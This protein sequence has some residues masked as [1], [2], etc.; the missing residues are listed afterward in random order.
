MIFYYIRIFEVKIQRFE[1]LNLIST[2]LWVWGDPRALWQV[3]Q[4]LRN[5]WCC[6]RNRWRQTCQNL[7]RAHEG[8]TW[9]K[10]AMKL[11]EIRVARIP[12]WVLLVLLMGWMVQDAS[13]SCVASLPAVCPKKLM[14]G[15]PN[16]N[17]FCFTV[18]HHLWLSFF[19]HFSPHLFCWTCRNRSTFLILMSTWPYLLHL[20][21]LEL[22]QW[23]VWTASVH[24]QLHQHQHR[25]LLEGV[26][27]MKLH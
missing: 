18:D 8:W 10:I 19:P 1:S 27:W 4:A 5:G 21:M 17:W 3:G 13:W 20:L 24:Q 14:L 15:T 2:W 12:E 16:L 11:D 7:E 26:I 25:W 9:P 22:F 6:T 23:A